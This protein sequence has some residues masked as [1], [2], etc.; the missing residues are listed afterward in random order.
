MVDAPR[1]QHNIYKN[2]TNINDQFY[3]ETLTTY[4]RVHN[5]VAY[6]QELR[7]LP[8]PTYRKPTKMARDMTRAISDTEQPA[9]QTLTMACL[10]CSK[11]NST[12]KHLF[13]HFVQRLRFLL[14]HHSTSPIKVTRFPFGHRYVTRNR[15]LKKSIF[16]SHNI[17]HSSSVIVS[18]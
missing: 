2:I 16:P 9:M 14:L 10:I 3:V 6:L 4:C 17:I 8:M 18:R 13:S 5:A 7:R 12:R 15:S 1:Q 11:C